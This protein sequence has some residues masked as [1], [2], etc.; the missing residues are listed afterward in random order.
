ME[1]LEI[2]IAM[3]KRLQEDNLFG[4]VT[5]CFEYGEIKWVDVNERT[6]MT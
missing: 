5:I 4:K 3:L 6:K 2:I 1:K